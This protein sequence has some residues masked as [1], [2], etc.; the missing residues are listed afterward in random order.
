MFV[1]TK[2]GSMFVVRC[3]LLAV[4]LL[5][6]VFVSYVLLCGVCCTLRVVW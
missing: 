2:C 6:I 5:F 1:V 3:V 4:C